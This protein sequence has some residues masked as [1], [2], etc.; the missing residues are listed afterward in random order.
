MGWWRCTSSPLP[1]ALWHYTVTQPHNIEVPRSLVEVV[2]SWNLPQHRWLKQ[3]VFRAGRGVVG[4]GGAVLLTY[5][6]STLLHGLSGQLALVLLS[7]GLYT[8]VE[9]GL[10]EKLSNILDASVGARR[11]VEGRRRWREGSAAVILANLLFGLLAM[12]H[13]AYLGV[14]FDQSSPEQV[15]RGTRQHH[16]IDTPFPKNCNNKK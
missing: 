5:V 11:E 3:Y 4:P 13:L 12:F 1:Q 9:H 15:R 7:I 10:R 16:Y 8:W 2:I 6:V 14:M